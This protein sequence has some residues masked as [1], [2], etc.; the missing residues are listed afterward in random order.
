[1][2]DI[3]RY[4][5]HLCKRLCKARKP[6]LQNLSFHFANYRLWDQSLFSLATT[7][8]SVSALETGM[9]TQYVIKLHFFLI[10]RIYSDMFLWRKKK[11]DEHWW[12]KQMEKR[13][14]AAM[15]ETECKKYSH[16][17]FVGVGQFRTSTSFPKA[18]WSYRK[19]N[20][21]Y[22]QTIREF[23]GDRKLLNVGVTLLAQV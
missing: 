12:P 18:L 8:A 21:T 15:T 4:C 14:L 19:P 1:M 10:M 23:G 3:F 16:G 6:D 11:F 2:V 17:D 7:K 13:K 20:N 9:R 5:Q 22:Y